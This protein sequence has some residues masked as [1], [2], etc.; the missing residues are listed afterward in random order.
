MTLYHCVDVDGVTMP[1]LYGKDAGPAMMECYT[2]AKKL[3]DEIR[4]VVTTPRARPKSPIS[5]MHDEL[6]AI[7]DSSCDRDGDVPRDIAAA[8]MTSCDAETIS[9]LMRRCSSVML[10]PEQWSIIAPQL[11]PKIAQAMI[12]ENLSF[13]QCPFPGAVAPRDDAAEVL[14]DEM[15]KCS[16]APSRVPKWVQSHGQGAVST[17]LTARFLRQMA[18]AHPISARYSIVTNACYQATPL[19]G[20]LCH[21]AGLRLTPEDFAKAPPTE[22]ITILEM[23]TSNH[24]RFRILEAIPSLEALLEDRSLI[25]RLR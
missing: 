9:L 6:C 12:D 1:W 16:S 3:S 10:S 20:I 18:A 14:I 22:S 13:S 17:K 2:L 23:T 11:T 25:D 8:V 5:K 4:R 24:G 19:H 7:I 21:M 15:G